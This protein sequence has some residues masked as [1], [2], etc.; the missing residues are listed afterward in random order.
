MSTTAQAMEAVARRR[1]DPAKTR[2][3]AEETPVTRAPVTNMF[4]GTR[5][6]EDSY[7]GWP[8]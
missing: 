4:R 7:I 6:R 1:V 3:R 2:W 5:K 8:K